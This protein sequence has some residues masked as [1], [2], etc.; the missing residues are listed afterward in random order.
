MRAD[1]PAWSWA[2]VEPKAPSGSRTWSKCVGLA[3]PSRRG[4]AALR[5]M[6][7]AFLSRQGPRKDVV[8]CVFDPTAAEEFH[9][10]PS[11]SFPHFAHVCRI[12]EIQRDALQAGGSRADRSNQ[13]R[14]R[15]RSGLRVPCTSTFRLPVAQP[16]WRPGYFRSGSDG[17]AFRRYRLRARGGCHQWCRGDRLRLSPDPA[18][19]LMPIRRSQREGWRE[20]VAGGWWVGLLTVLLGARSKEHTSE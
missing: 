2:R 12:R 8:G 7:A 19:G 1:R 3:W 16:R 5:G 9:A 18:H 14:A 4:I 20:V 11:P 10:K 13:R 6:G 17:Q 15:P